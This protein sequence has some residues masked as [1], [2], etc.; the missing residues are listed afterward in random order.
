MKYQITI[1]RPTVALESVDTTLRWSGVIRQ[2]SVAL[3]SSAARL[4]IWAHPGTTAICWFAIT[5]PGVIMLGNGLT[6]TSDRKKRDRPRF[7]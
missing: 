4:R 2:K 1:T 6:K 7:S 3:F 5:R